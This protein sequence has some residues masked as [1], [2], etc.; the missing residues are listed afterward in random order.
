MCNDI[1][2]PLAQGKTCGTSTSIQFLGIIL[3]AV[4]MHARLPEDKLV[5]ARNLLL[6]LLRKQKVTLKEL[7]SVIGLL[8]FCSEV[9]VPGRPFLRRLIDL[10]IGVPRPY[11]HIRLTKQAKLD[12]GVWLAFLQHFNGRAFFFDDNFLTGDF[13]ELYTDAAGAIGYGA[14]FG[15][16]WFC[17]L[18]PAKWRSHNVAVLELYPIVAAVHVWGHAW[19]NKSVCFFTDNEALVPIINNQTSRDPHIMALIR[20]LVL[21]CL[22]FNINFAARNIPGRFNILADKLSRSQVG[23]FHDLAPWANVIP[24]IVP[25]SM[26]PAGLGSL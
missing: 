13:L 2:V 11:F 17:G 15:N 10:T 8:S 1:G 18:W 12:V 3:D 26:S 6:A 22:R 14:L 16:A 4:H 21:A 24:V 5:R 20:P 7:Q 25:Y 23:E 9:V 19:A